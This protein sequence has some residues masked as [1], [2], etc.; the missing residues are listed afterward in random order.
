LTFIPK[1]F[2]GRLKSL[3]RNLAP[4]PDNGVSRKR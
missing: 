2:A 3:K 1:G 4:P